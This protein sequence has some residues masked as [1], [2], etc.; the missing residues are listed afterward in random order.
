MKKLVIE[1]SRWQR[2]DKHKAALLTGEGTMC[3]LGFLAVDCGATPGDILDETTPEIVPNIAWPED[4]IEENEA[5]G[6][7]H[8]SRWT[9]KAIDINDSPTLSE[10]YRERD[11]AE[12]FAK[13]GYELEFVE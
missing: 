10:E 3:C 8:D 6:R 13:I 7:F 5:A 12:H 9:C 2:G 4:V 11:L 1:R